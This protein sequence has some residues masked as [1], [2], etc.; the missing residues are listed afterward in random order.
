MEERIG[1]A[2]HGDRTDGHGPL[3]PTPRGTSSA[4]SSSA[5]D[6]AATPI[7]QAAVV[8]TGPYELRG[9]RRRRQLLRRPHPVQGLLRRRVRRAGR[10]RRASGKRITLT[11]GGRFAEGSTSG[12]YFTFDL[13][14]SRNV[15]YRIGVSYVSVENARAE[16][17]GRERHVGL[18]RRAAAPPK[19]RWNR[20]LGLIEVE[21]TNPDR[22]GQFYTHLYRA[23]IHPNLCSDV[24]GEYMGAD[25]RV[26]KTRSRQ[27]TSFSN[28]D[29]YRTQIQLLAMLT[30]DVASDVVLSHQRL[31]RTVGRRIPPLGAGQ[32]RDRRHA[33]RPHAD[34]DRQR[35]GLRRAGLRP[36]S[37]SSG[38]CA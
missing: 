34:P 11:P 19:R 27:Y 10:R 25:F 1:G 29:T 31:R 3:R 4:R 8:V 36:L 12:V 37:R 17:P 15:Q 13:G 26:H 14:K 21:G 5:P 28:W 33:G 18:R 30:P 2:A 38:S 7:E 9:L 20:Y 35:L 32:H 23:L 16:S 24:N 6:I 22:I